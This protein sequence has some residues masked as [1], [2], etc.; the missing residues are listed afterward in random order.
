MT[1]L[2]ET[3]ETGGKDETG[4]LIPR[5]SGAVPAAGSDRVA[6]TRRTVPCL[7]PGN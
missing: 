7:R 2:D 5:R 3:M 1:D 4:F 6:Q